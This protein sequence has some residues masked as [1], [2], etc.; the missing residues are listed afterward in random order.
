MQ[1]TC[2]MGIRGPTNIKRPILA[3]Q[4]IQHSDVV[5]FY[6]VCSARS[7]ECQIYLSPEYSD[8]FICH[9]KYLHTLVT[10]KRMKVWRLSQETTC[11]VWGLVRRVFGGARR[12]GHG[13]ENLINIPLGAFPCPGYIGC[14]RVSPLLR[15]CLYFPLTNKQWTNI[16]LAFMNWNFSSCQTLFSHLPLKMTKNRNWVLFLNNFQIISWWFFVSS[17]VMLRW[18]YPSPPLENIENT[19]PEPLPPSSCPE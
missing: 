18:Q 17:Y 14:L 1:G 8:F 13:S 12:V 2:D 16:F 4:R 11:K 10:S 6:A 3:I 9:Y 7:A 5:H 19:P 15:I